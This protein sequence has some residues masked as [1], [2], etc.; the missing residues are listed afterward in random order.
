MCLYKIGSIIP[1]VRRQ[2]RVFYEPCRHCEYYATKNIPR[3]IKCFVN[4]KNPSENMILFVS[5]DSWYALYSHCIFC[6][7][8]PFLQVQ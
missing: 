7:S 5:F 8:F 3:Y 2:R 1:L 4:V 6:F